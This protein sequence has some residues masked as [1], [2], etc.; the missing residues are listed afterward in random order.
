MFTYSYVFKCVNFLYIFK[1]REKKKEKNRGWG[2]Q[3][4]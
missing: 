1:L 3:R 4:V 2:I